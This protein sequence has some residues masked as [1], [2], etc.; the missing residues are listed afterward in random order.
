MAIRK[1]IELS[2][3]FIKDE[4]VEVVL[5]LGSRDGV[6]ALGISNFYPDAKIYSFEC[7]P[8]T[9]KE[10]Y[11]NTLGNLNIEIIEKA[12]MDFTGENQVSRRRPR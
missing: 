5:D 4:D 9:L 10:C 2:K 7:N 12:V 11:D 6:E 8:H 1:F 3:S